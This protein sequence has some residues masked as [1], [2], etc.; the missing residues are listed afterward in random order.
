MNRALGY[1]GFNYGGLGH[2][3]VPHHPFF[4]PRRR[5]VPFFFLSPFFF[6]FFREETDRDGTYYAQHHCKE[7][8]TMGSLAQQYNVPQPILEAMNP[9]LQNPNA[10]V[11]GTVTYIP[12]LDKMYCHKMYMEQDATANNAVPPQYPQQ[13]MMG[14]FRDPNKPPQPSHN[15]PI[16]P[17]A[18]IPQYPGVYP[19]ATEP[20]GGQGLGFHAGGYLGGHD[21][22][23]HA[24]GHLGGYGAGVHAGG[25]LDGHSAGVHT[26]GH[27]GGYGAGVHAGGHLDGHGAGVHTGGH[28]GGYGAGV[29]AGGHL[30]GHGAGVH[31]GGHLGNY[32]AG[33]HADVQLGKH[34]LNVNA[35]GELDTPDKKNT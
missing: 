18:H 11:S 28:L 3:G 14:D 29:H 7:G 21:V 16:Y 25:H 6:P 15:Q 13:Q 22:G 5:F 9:H 2:F 4:F 17:Y 24:G 34:G 1:G 10:L 35:G 31:T 32:A 33:V 12:R 27:L 20:Q 23:V 8:D 19:K 30:D 26:G